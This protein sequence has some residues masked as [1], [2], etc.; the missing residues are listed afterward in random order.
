MKKRLDLVKYIL[1]NCDHRIRKDDERS[2]YSK[3]QVA[4]LNMK[5]LL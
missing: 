3:Y 4:T 2:R 1:D 5:S